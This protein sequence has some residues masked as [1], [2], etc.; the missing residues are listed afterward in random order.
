MTDDG[1]PSVTAIYQ[2]HGEVWAEA[3]NKELVERSWLDR[4]SALLP[5]RGAV[6]DIGCGSGLPIARELVRRGFDVT[7]VDST[8]TMISLFR[9][10]LP[11]T[12]AHLM[13]MRQLAL[14]RR[15]AGYWLGTA[16]FIS[17]LTSSGQCSD[18]FKP[19][20]LLAP[21]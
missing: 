15:F 10:N 1:Q 18:V 13:D 7:G 3:R 12:P 8:P 21:L 9:R 5:A 19:M 2:R 20:P 14:D 11:D 17:R 16:S 6:L 4:F